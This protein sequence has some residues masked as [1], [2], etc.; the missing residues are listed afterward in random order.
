MDESSFSSLILS[1]LRSVRSSLALLHSIF[2][3]CVF[4]VEVI[5]H[6]TPLNKIMYYIEINKHKQHS[7]C[8]THTHTSPPCSAM[9]WC[10]WADI[11]FQTKRKS[12]DDWHRK[13]LIELVVVESERKIDDGPLNVHF[14]QNTPPAPPKKKNKEIPCDPR[15]TKCGKR[16]MF[17]MTYIRTADK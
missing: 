11:H 2:I 15:A 4:A 6:A 12:I 1:F 10:S 5:A 17:N 16:Q 13:C 8:R 14:V 9:I 7:R 3:I